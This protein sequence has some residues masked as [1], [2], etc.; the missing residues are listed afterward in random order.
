MTPVAAAILERALAW[1]TPG[2]ALILG[3]CGPQ[4]CGKSTACAQVADALAHAGLKAGLLSLDDL[5]LGRAERAALAARIHPLFATRGPPGTHDT[6]LGIATIDA[7]RR[8]AAVRLPRFAKPLDEP[9][10]PAAWPELGA[11]CDVLLFEGWCVGAR[12]QPEAMLAA[13]ANALERDEDPQ[14]I[15]RHAV[16][17]GLTGTTG[18]LFAR[19]DRLVCLTAPSFDCVFGWRREQEQA[20]LALAGAGGAPHAMDDAALARFIA[21]YERL[22]R[23]IAEEMPVRADFAIALDAQ[24]GI[25]G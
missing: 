24:R 10:P 17:A 16:N 6:A 14:G 18:A 3:V 19:I 12:P 25:A 9:L 23:W 1:R 2:Q 5:Y 13:P 20:M 4:G 22:T 21:H 11:G 7:V 8:G 15:W